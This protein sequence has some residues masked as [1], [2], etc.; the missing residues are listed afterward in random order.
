MKI[1]QSIEALFSAWKELPVP[2]GIYVDAE[3]SNKLSKAK[4]WA[5]SSK[6]AKDQTVVE[7]AFG[8]VPESMVDFKVKSFLTCATLQDI[9]QNKLENNPALKI[10]NTVVFLEALV[11]YLE[12]DE[13]LD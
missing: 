8:N 10:E 3:N 5:I 4:F 12:Y 11:H 2:G 1:F 7:T 6:E 9:V 13:F